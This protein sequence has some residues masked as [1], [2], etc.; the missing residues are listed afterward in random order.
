[1]QFSRL[2]KWKCSLLPSNA[3]CLLVCLFFSLSLSVALKHN[4]QLHFS[5]SSLLF[6]NL[7]AYL[8]HN[9]CICILYGRW[10]RLRSWHQL[11]Y[12]RN[13]IS[14]NG[15]MALIIT[16]CSWSP[17]MDTKH[18]EFFPFFQS[19]SLCIS[20]S[21]VQYTE[22]LTVHCACVCAYGIDASTA[23]ILLFNLLNFNQVF[24]RDDQLFQYKNKK[25]QK[26]ITRI[27]MCHS[28]ACVRWDGFLLR[29]SSECHHL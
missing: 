13:V 21:V 18:T 11:F 28:C 4:A 9:L 24:L 22:R 25:F 27:V 17:W 8:M 12:I 6:D 16:I 5:H 23:L 14:T 7:I 19:L 15:T 2:N 20:F 10:R 29:F 26:Q 1:M 3:F